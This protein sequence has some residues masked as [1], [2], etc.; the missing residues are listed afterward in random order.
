VPVRPERL[1]GADSFAVYAGS[2]AAVCDLSQAAPLQCTVPADRSPVPGAQLTVGSTL[3]DPATGDG[4]Y[5]VAAVRHGAQIPR[6][7]W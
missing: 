1:P 6:R 4:R 7:P 3:P 2:L 5:Y